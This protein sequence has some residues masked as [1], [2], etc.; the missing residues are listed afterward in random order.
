METRLER[1][2]VLIRKKDGGVEVLRTIF[3]AHAEAHACANAWANHMKDSITTEI[4]TITIPVSQ[5]DA[6][7]VYVPPPAKK[8]LFD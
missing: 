6:G 8:T 4:V 5:V 3:V 1:F 2:A 7:P